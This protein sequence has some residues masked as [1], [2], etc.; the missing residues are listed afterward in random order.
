LAEPLLSLASTGNTLSS[1]SQ[2]S[3]PGGDGNGVY[4]DSF[5]SADKNRVA[6][7][8][9]S[10]AVQTFPL[11]VTV[12]LNFNNNLVNDSVAEFWMFFANDDAPGDNLG[13]DYGTI[14]ALLVQD[15]TN[16]DIQGLVDAA[17][18]TYNYA[19]DG[20]TQRGAGS[21]STDVPVVIV[22]IGLT[23]A[24]YVVASGTIGNTGLT[25][26]LVAA[27]ERNYANP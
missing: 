14:D 10:D 23:Q 19:Y 13:R 15:D 24:Q 11:T 7:R 18:K 21:A 1:L 27:L 22:A 5:S 26:S 3:N 12:T 8:D 6:F 9:N 20:N 4:V 17:Q 25:A 2:V 16:T